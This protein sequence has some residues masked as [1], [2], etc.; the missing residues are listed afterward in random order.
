MLRRDVCL[1][2]YLCTT[3]P[4]GI[5]FQKLELLLAQRLT[6]LDPTWTSTNELIA[7]AVPSLDAGVV[8]SVTVR[9]CDISPMEDDN[10]KKT[11]KPWVIVNHIKEFLKSGCDTQSFPFQLVFKKAS[12]APVTPYSVG[13][14]N[15]TARNMA[16]KMII[17]GCV[18]AG[19]SDAEVTALMP[20]LKTLFSLTG[21]AHTTGDWKEDRMKA[22]RDKMGV[23]ASQ[24]LRS[25]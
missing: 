19:L 10:W 3:F 8:L 17:I 25:V 15:G 21:V 11:S 14:K 16:I 1:G 22:I 9:P 23:A 13:V 20:K 18:N 4:D 5:S 12:G 7:N 2:S 24:T 6:K